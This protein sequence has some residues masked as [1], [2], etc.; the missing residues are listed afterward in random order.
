MSRTVKE[1]IGRTDDTPVPPRVKMRVL[2]R[3][4]HCC[5]GCGRPLI[6]KR[7]TCDHVVALINGGENR[8]RN[9]QPLGDDCCNKTK[10]RADVALKSKNYARR[11]KHYGAMRSGRSQWACGRDT[12]FKKK[13]D[14][15][16][17]RR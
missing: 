2:A 10:T 8:E 17:V 9:L 12:P 6:G 7:W 11:A 3:F 14:G 1:W 13:I 15:R 16:V 4:D 5:A